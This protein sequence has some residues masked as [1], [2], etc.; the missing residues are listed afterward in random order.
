MHWLLKK[1]Q[2]LWL[3]V[4]SR[5]C[6]LEEE[7]R[8]GNRF[9]SNSDTKSRNNAAVAWRGTVEKRL[10]RSEMIWLLCC[11][12]KAGVLHARVAKRP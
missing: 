10:S 2:I 12:K 9:S 7:C 6:C 8:V 5:I 4:T 11:T 3:N 1:E